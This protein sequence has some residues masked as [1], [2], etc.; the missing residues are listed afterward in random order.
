MS[1][2]AAVR[3]REPKREGQEVV[4]VV[5]EDS[6]PPEHPARLLWT[7]LGDF[8]L[9]G[10]ADEAKAVEGR[11]GRA[12]YSPRMMLTLWGYALYDGVV[13]AREIAR[14][15]QSDVNYRWIVGDRPVQRTALADF[16][17]HH[18]HALVDLMAD[19]LGVLMEA[20]LLFL[21]NQH[22]AQDGTRIQ[23][24]AS[25]RS[26]VTAAGLA[27]RREQAELHL[28]AVLAKLDDPA[29]AAAEQQARERG[30]MDVLD[31]I[32]SA[33]TAL[34]V[35]QEQRSNSQNKKRSTTVPTVSTTDPDAR[36]MKMANG[37]FVPAYNVQFATVGDPSG[38]PV[39]IV[40]VRV[41]NQGND[42]ASL[43][44]MREQV[45]ALT[46]STPVQVVVDADH[47][48]LEDLRRAEREHLDIIS[49][50][51]DH[52]NPEGRDQDEVTRKWMAQMATEQA[53]EVYRGRKALAERPNAIVKTW[54]GLDRLPVRGLERVEGLMVL[55]A[56]MLN[57][58]EH[59]RHW[60]N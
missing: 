51:P 4:F 56:I 42:K 7:A 39:A 48:T 9:S 53:R 47:L 30:A 29:L 21:P 34:K 27:S 41:T 26:F 60:L 28:K 22:L 8:D 16:L 13:H 18:R 37:G 23:A 35:V 31:R 43:W 19:V 2:R 3:I 40:G 5:A 6:L 59:R 15:I 49:T 14:K 20:G 10:F 33:T 12:V 17:A 45:T 57:L 25:R 52:W 46:G 55:A 32:K 1:K 38:G 54:M 58:H 24:N 36:L 50:C 44:P 11:A